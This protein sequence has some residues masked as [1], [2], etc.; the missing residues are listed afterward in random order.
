MPTSHL[1]ATTTPAFGDGNRTATAREETP[2]NDTDPRPDDTNADPAADRDSSPGSG[3]DSSPDL[4]H[5]YADST[6]CPCG[7]KT[8]PGRLCR[9]CSA[10]AIWSRRKDDV[11]RK[12]NRTRRRRHRPT[13]RTEPRTGTGPKGRRS[14]R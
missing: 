13:N 14:D 11:I 7:A 12:Q 5:L 9:K 10:R 4:S 8:V 2:M 3:P 1:P 6:L